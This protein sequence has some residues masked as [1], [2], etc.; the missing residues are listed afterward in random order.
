MNKAL[1]M[2]RNLASK[3]K[4]TEMN[5]GGKTCYACGGVVKASSLE[6]D[7]D[8]YGQEMASD[9]DLDYSPE[10]SEEREPQES[11][12]DNDAKRSSFLRSY[13]ISRRM[14]QG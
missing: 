2:A 12:G 1:S 9:D 7:G 10:V 6:H 11:E 4:G 13:M 3:N 8:D 5:Q 14:R